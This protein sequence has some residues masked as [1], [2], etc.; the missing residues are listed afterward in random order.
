MPSAGFCT[1]LAKLLQQ[2]IGPCAQQLLLDL[3]Q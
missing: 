1:C 3:L 2:L